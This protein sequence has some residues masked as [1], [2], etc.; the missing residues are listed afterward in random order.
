MKILSIDTSSN[1]CSVALLDNK[2]LIKE[3]KSNDGLTHS[4]KLM[5]MISNILSDTNLSLQNIDL[6]VCDKGPGSFTGI[7]IGV[8]TIMA[9]ADSLNINTTGVSSLEAL[10]Y[11]VKENGIICSLI[12]AKNSNCY[13]GIYSLENEVYTL[14]EEQ[15]IDNI[16][17]IISK[18]QKYNKPITFVGS[19]S[20]QYKNIII[21]KIKKYFFSDFN[22]LSSY[23]LG[24]AGYNK[25]LN[26]QNENLL[27]LYLR[28]SQAEEVLKKGL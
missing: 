25:Y 7:R 1:L 15:Y 13:C 23:N 24:I 16:E 9:F 21:N 17:K 14:L 12:D 19:G 27:P 10:A 2:T 20:V 22:D 3:I 28:K 5:P 18:L 26:N 8:S 4:E 6:L 11:N